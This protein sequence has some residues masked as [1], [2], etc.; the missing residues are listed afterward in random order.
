MKSGIIDSL[1]SSVNPNY[2]NNYIKTLENNSFV[3]EFMNFE[4]DCLNHFYMN[5]HTVDISITNDKMK[6]FLFNYKSELEKLS[7]EFIKKFNN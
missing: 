6:K 2:V 7:N 1:K 3:F 4:E 5:G